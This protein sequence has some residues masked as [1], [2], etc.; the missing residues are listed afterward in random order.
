MIRSENL[1]K[2]QMIKDLSVSNMLSWIIDRLC[3]FNGARI[4]D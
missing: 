3:C 2:I 1:D 4:G